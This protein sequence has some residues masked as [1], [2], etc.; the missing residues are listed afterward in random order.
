MAGMSIA[1]NKQGV[2]VLVTGGLLQLFLG[3]IYVWS[4]FVAPVSARLDWAPD[5]VKLT[6]SFMLSFFVIGILAGGR[7]LPKLGAQKVTLLGGLMLAAGMCAA[8]FVP[9]SAAWLIYIAYG[10]V[11]GL[12]V[13]AAYNAVITCAQKWFPQN[14]GFATGISVCAFGF[15]TV[16]FAPLIEWLIGSFGVQNA[17]LILAGTYLLVVLAAFGFIRLPEDSGGGAASAALLAKRQFTLKEAM[18][19]KEFYFITLSIMLGTAAFFILNPSLKALAPER[20]LS[21]AMGTGLVMLTGVAN[22]LGRLA[23]PL[24]SDKL[25]STRGGIVPLVA[26]A[27]CAA[28]LI[29]ARG[30]LFMVLAALI[31]FCYGGQS[32]NSSVITADYF[33][34]KNVASNYGA[35]MVGFA[36]SALSFP[37][38]FGLIESLTAKFAVLAGLAAA[39]AALLGLLLAGKRRPS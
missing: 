27:L 1:R 24:L 22:A 36:L 5:K 32:G 18:A 12:G 17:F 39:G 30:P 16:I 15:S 25:G 4:V 9:P 10:V 20:G 3:I 7:L 23:I 28:G 31:A 8:A 21:A 19:T 34:I 6:T 29:F 14:R 38:G 33:G 2:K 26:T 11:G 37:F 35:I 13:G